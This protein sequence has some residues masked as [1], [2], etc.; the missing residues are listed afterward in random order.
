MAEMTVM[1]FAVAIFLGSAVSQFFGTIS[2]GLVAPVIGGVF[3]GAQ[4]GL[5]KWTVQLGPVKLALGD[6]LSATVN[7]VIAILVVYL[8]LPYIRTY[9]P[10]QGGRR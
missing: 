1:S 6:V 9:S 7:F 8:T 4:A 3:P 5:E 10:I 2:K